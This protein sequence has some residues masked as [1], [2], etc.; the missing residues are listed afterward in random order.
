MAAEKAETAKCILRICHDLTEKGL[1]NRAWGNVSARLS[2]D[3]F[4]ITPSGSKYEDMTEEDLVEVRI[5]DLSWSGE[6]KPSSEKGIH[7]E[8][9][10]LRPGCGFI[11]HTHQKFASA[12]SV[13]GKDLQL[14]YYR[15]IPEKH[16]RTLG[17]VVPCAEYGV[18]TTA[19]LAKG[20]AAAAKGQPECRALLIQCHGA[21]CMGRDGAE[22]LEAALDLEDVCRRGYERRCGESVL[23]EE[24]PQLVSESEGRYRIHIRTPY[25]MEMSRR[26]RTVYPYLDDVAKI[27]GPSVRCV[28]QDPTSAE[29][30][31]ACSWSSSK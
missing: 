12:I 20:V 15:D 22:A 5:S 30:R 8:I 25:V 19:K 28:R 13:A 2:E 9:Y 7:S 10:Q 29:I 24:G 17:P 1:V 16:I 3:T 21:V 4:L 23:T 26:G 14:T 31:K 27:A 11:I 18:S 6:R